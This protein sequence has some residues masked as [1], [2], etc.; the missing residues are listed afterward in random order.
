MS[1]NIQLR[2]KNL[3]RRADSSNP[4]DIANFLGIKIKP[5]NMPKHINGFW[6]PIL[7]RK[8]I[9]VNQELEEW[10][11]SAVIAHEIGHI[12]LHPQYHYFCIRNRTY[13]CIQKHE[14]EA[15]NFSVE[16]LK[17]SNSNIDSNFVH[18]FLE[19]GWK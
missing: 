8:F 1:Y 16:L 11:Q 13:F 15:D 5:V 14:E 10:Q 17:Y 19:D 12:L 6:K 18:L 2:V 9:F 7:K 3:I 4:Y